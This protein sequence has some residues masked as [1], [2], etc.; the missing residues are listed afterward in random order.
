LERLELLL[1]VGSD[2]NTLGRLDLL[3]ISIKAAKENSILFGAGAYDTKNIYMW[4]MGSYDSDIYQIIA[5]SGFIGLGIYM[6]VQV[7][8]LWGA[9]SL[10]N[11]RTDKHFEVTAIS[12]L[13][14]FEMLLHSIISTSYVH[15]PT[16]TTIGFVF[17]CIEA[18][19][20]WSQA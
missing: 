2:T 11:R 18:G 9:L 4:V 1:F 13:F 12:I 5:R 8:A 14:L 7:S 17:I 15:Y 6:V 3:A 10:M 19:Q 16:I 20:L